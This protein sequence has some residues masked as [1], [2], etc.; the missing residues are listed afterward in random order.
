MH[1]PVLPCIASRRPALRCRR[2][3]LVSCHA[4]LTA[5]P[6]AAAV[7][8]TPPAC[9]Y[10]GLLEQL[11][12]KEGGP[13]SL[14]RAV[15]KLTSAFPATYTAGWGFWVPGGGGCPLPQARLPAPLVRPSGLPAGMCAC[16]LACW[17]TL[18]LSSLSC[19]PPPPAN[20][21]N[22]M[23]VPPGSRVLFVNA[24]GLLWNAFLSFE[25]ST[26]GRLGAAAGAAAAPNAAAARKRR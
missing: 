16:L 11:G 5:A 18:L 6:V 3:R 21:L 15:A 24:A 4:V 25:N 26:K 19:P 1:G 22:F 9:S 10:M 7:S 20:L 14:Q 2:R 13:P 23:L 12:Q 17:L 8:A